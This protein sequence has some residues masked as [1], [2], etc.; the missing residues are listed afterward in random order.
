MRP[1]ILYLLLTF[2]LCA[3]AACAGSGNAP[4]SGGEAVVIKPDAGA[5]NA[6]AYKRYAIESAIVEY[7]VSGAQ[8]GTET[9]YFDR[10]GRREA[11]L[12]NTAISLAGITQEQNTLT[13]TEG[14][15]IYNINLD[16]RSG[17]KT[18]NPLFK[19]VL[20][21]TPDK[22]LANLGLR[23][24][25]RMGGVK[26]GAEEVAGKHCEVWEVG[27]LQSKSWLWKTVPLKTQ[28]KLGGLEV[29]K[30]AT[31]FEEGAK[32]PE[33]RFAVPAGIKL[34]EGQAIQK[35]LERLKKAK[36]TN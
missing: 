20:A 15:L 7:S 31:K 8:Q 4:K 23:M 3:F 13:L 12:S 18:V 34:S 24:L 9:L 5:A 30:T 17:T 6:P 19:Q 28:A 14:E 36:P 21:Q 1:P 22:D 29:V 16:Q 35:T 33:D 32:I 2:L 10:W 27:D 11:K 26:I 25:E